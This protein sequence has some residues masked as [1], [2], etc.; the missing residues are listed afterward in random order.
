[1]HGGIEQLNINI[2]MDTP[3]H[4]RNGKKLN[5]KEEKMKP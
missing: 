3:K 1:M 2:K 4:N 5:K